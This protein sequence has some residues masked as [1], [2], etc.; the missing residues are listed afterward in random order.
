MLGYRV[1]AG[2]KL[3]R[4]P[5]TT[6]IAHVLIVTRADDTNYLLSVVMTHG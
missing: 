1:N 5:L 3:S 4:N 2:H 6:P